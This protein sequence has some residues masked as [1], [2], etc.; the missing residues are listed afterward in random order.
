MVASVA[1]MEAGVKRSIAL[2]FVVTAALLSSSS[3]AWAF[4]KNKIVYDEFDWKTYSSTHFDVYFYEEERESLQK[5]VNLA[6]SAYDEI[7]RKFDFQVTDRIPLIYYQTHSAF[8][9]TNVILMFIPEGVGAFAE[10]GKNRMVLPIDLPDEKLYALLKHELTH[11]FEYEIIYQGSIRRE[12]RANPPTWLMEGLASFMAEDEDTTD[13]MVLRDAVVNDTLPSINQGF[14]GFF[15]YRFGHAVFRFMADKWGMEGVRDFIYEYRNSLGGSIER[16]LRRTFD[17]SVEEF[18]TQFRTW[19]RKQYLPAL[20]TKGEPTEYGKRFRVREGTRSQEMSPVP[21]PSGDLLASITTY[22]EDVDVALFNVP[23][24]KLFRNLSKGYPDKYEYVIAQFATTGPVMGRDIAFAPEGDRIAFFVKRE[25][26][27]YLMIVNALSGEIEVSERMDV[28]QQLNPAFSPDG[29][30][31]AFHGFRGNQADI[32]TYHLDTKEVTNLTDDAF[33]DA[34]PVYSPDGR[35]LYY[36]SVVDGFAKLFRLDLSDPSRRYQLTQG[37]WNDRDAWVG[38]GGDR[39]Y[40]SSDRPT[41][42]AEEVVAAGLLELAAKESKDE[43]KTP[44]ADLESFASFNVYSLD[45]QSGDVVQYT[46]VIGGAFTPVV[47]VGDEGKETLVFSSFYKGRWNLY[48]TP[49]D[50]NLGVTKTIDIPVEPL[51]GEERFEFLPPVEVTLD[52]NEIKDG[53]RFRLFIEDISVNGGVTSDQTLVSRSVIRMSDMLGNRRF[54]A[55]L[56]SV[57]TFSNFDFLYLDL[58][59]RWTWGVRLFDN[60]TFYVDPASLDDPSLQRRRAYRVTGA[61]GLLSYPFDRYR[62][63][64]FGLGYMYRDIDIPLGNPFPAEGEDPTPTLSFSDDF[65]FVF[66]TFTGDSTVYKSFGPVSGRRY[67]V[68]G[69]YLADLSGGGTLSADFE[70]DFR[71]YLQVTSRSLLAARVYA[72]Y[73]DGNR[74]NFYYFG[75]LNTLRGYDFRSIVGNRAFYGNFE[76]RFP[77]IDIIAT[78]LINIRDVRGTLFFDIG[79][80]WFDGD[81]FEPWTDGRLDDALA[82]VGWGLSFRFLGLELHWDFARRTDLDKIS[83]TTETSFW[84]GQTF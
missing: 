41:G 11:I 64:E 66:S 3:P 73:S 1:R 82:S 56:D 80:A 84:I 6:E 33:F 60:R 8:E 46:D 15:A 49:T 14:G 71:Q 43:T 17:L 58:S 23:E 38:P 25:R 4:G 37:E 57:S 72:G 69:Q 20:I 5:V 74:P 50:E 29:R 44:A 51:L 39:I 81:D 54:I 19:L 52:E 36:S 21:A 9:Q 59:D 34:A 30:T 63:V 53:D 13:L 10:P 45:L 18:D 76:Y 68:S 70:T 40:F 67:N 47:F 35:W 62:R 28:E 75:G 83:D 32:F 61:L 55:S 24:R 7:S 12:M 48:S 16:P 26:G 2:L 31:V 77:L 42:R 65:P 27:R 22:K 78:P 79:G